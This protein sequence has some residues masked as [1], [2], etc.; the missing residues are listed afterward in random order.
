M[1]DDGLPVGFTG[2]IEPFETGTVAEAV[3]N[4]SSLI[5]KNVG[6]HDAGAF[7][8]EMTRLFRTLAASGAGD[9]DDLAGVKRA[10]SL[11][12][13]P[14]CSQRLPWRQTTGPAPLHRLPIA[15]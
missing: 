5:L 14:C 3:G 15:P 1:S 4:L 2:D 7:A 10:M 13:L 6:D 9:Q 8:N 11:T 12:A